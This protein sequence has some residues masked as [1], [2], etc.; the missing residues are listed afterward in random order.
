MNCCSIDGQITL[1]TMLAV[2]YVVGQLNSPIEQMIGFA[3]SWQNAKIS[4]DRMREIHKLQDEE[5]P[6]SKLIRDLSTADFDDD[7]QEADKHGEGP[8][9]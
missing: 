7:E 3:Q 6:N 1:G 9:A 2:Q 8:P 5:P 4:L